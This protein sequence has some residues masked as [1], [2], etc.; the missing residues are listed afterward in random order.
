MTALGVSHGSETTWYDN[1]L[2]RL[3]GCF[4]VDGEEVPMLDAVPGDVNL[5][6]TVRDILGMRTQSRLDA[7][8]RFGTKGLCSSG[9]FRCVDI[10]Q[11]A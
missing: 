6:M 1:E 11:R 2:E 3:K 8:P 10:L 5:R 4:F 7:T 9:G